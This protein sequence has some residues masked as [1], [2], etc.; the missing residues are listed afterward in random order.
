MWW[1]DR[2]RA[3]WRAVPVLLALAL[4][5]LVGAPARGATGLGQFV[6]RCPYSHTLSDDPIVF[7]GQPGVAHSHD[8]FG[9]RTVNASSTVGTMLLGETTCRVPSDTAGYWS[10]TLY[11]NSVPVVPTVMRIYY[12]GDANED[13]ETIPAG[14]QMIGGDMAASA[15][16]ENPHVHWS[17][18]ETREIRTPRED[19]PYDCTPWARAYPFVDGLVAIVDMPTCWSGTGLTPDTVV[20]QVDGRCPD[21]F[22]HVLPRLSERVHYGIMD[23]TNPDGSMAISLSSGPYWSFHAD[24]WNTW[25]QARLDE[26]VTEC[27]IA[28]V[29]CGAVDASARIDWTRQFGTTRYDLAWAS[30]IHDDAVYVAG[31][32]NLALEGQTYRR[33]YDAFVRRYDPGG[34]ERWT[35][36]FGSSGIDEILAIAA[37]E[38]GVT[39]VGSTDGRL[40]EQRAAGGVD[41]LVA[42]FGPRGR[43]LW[44]RQLGTRDDDRATAVV[45][46]GTST[47]VAGST[48]G[49]LGDG[50]LGRTDAFVMEIDTAGELLW[51]RQFGTR[52]ADEALALDVRDGILYVAG[53]TAGPVGDAFLGGASDGFVAT[54]SRFG[55]PAWQRQV[56]TSGTDR[57]TAISVRADG[58]FLAGSTD[59]ALEEPTPVG[60]LDAFVVKLDDQGETTWVRQFGSTAD[61]EATA[62]VVDRK[63]LYVAGSASGA[64]PDGELLGEWDGFARKY[65]P[66]GTHLWTRQIGTNDYDRV[67][68]LS[69]EPTGL[70]LTG[71]THGAFE[72]FVNAGDRDVFVLRV[73][74]S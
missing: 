36:Q 71:T 55:E 1:G 42:R 63:G 61:D 11:H 69:V 21:G 16:D 28:R 33:R 43:P 18:G 62:L 48:D 12:L 51:V 29:R 49:A 54:F 52:E 5:P 57:V 68:G 74:F 31:F 4:L 40:P 19:T 46:A 72:G 60:G 47:F 59:G 25:Q 45:T 73:A 15:P 56:G 27:V 65:L 44:V 53:G 41:V 22:E 2:R 17:C 39:V 66:N 23:P 20:Y 70:Y 35:R 30:A 64:L 32:T 7:P 58:V 6:L 50:R 10:P 3:V 24:F 34:G 13:V 26:L 37:D 38:G 14:L 8:F 67:Y 9:N